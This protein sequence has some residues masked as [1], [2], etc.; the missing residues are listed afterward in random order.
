MS[1]R[2]PAPPPDLPG[3]TV[4]KLLGSGGFADVYLYEQQLPRRSVAV[5]VLLPG[6]AD[7]ELLAQF[8][9]EANLMAALSTH[10]AIV[11]IHQAGISRDGRPYLV[12][13]HCSRP[14]LAARYRSERLGAAEVLRVG[15]RLAGAVE[16][17]HRAGI[18]HRDIK[19]ANVLTTDFGHPVLSDFGISVQSASVRGPAGR[20]SGESGS[21]GMSIPWSAPEVFT[22]HGGDERA[23]IY[24]LAATLYTVLASR[25]PFDRPGGPNT[26]ADLMN[27]IRTAPLPPIGRD[28]IPDALERVITRGMDRN[29]GARF[30]TALDFARAL[31]QVEASLRLSPTPIDVLDEDPQHAAEELGDTPATRVRALTVI[32]PQAPAAGAKQSGVPQFANPGTAAAGGGGGFAPP[33]GGQG[34][35]AAGWSGPGT[36]VAAQQFS[37]PPPA[38]P[39]R[40]SSSL[41][42]WLGGAAVLAVA[43][44]VAVLA[45]N[46][47]DDPA[48]P[49]SGPAL[50]SMSPQG[51]MDVLPAPKVAVKVVDGKSVFSWAPPKGFADGDFY[52]WSTSPDGGYKTIRDTTVTV[53]KPSACLYLQAVSKAGTASETEHRCS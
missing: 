16:T 9:A 51:P 20:P 37:A 1:R 25:S 5:K 28:D 14:N 31:Q 32:H 26:S 44:V 45:L 50:P 3:Y 8:D 15:I 46:G 12:M 10:P 35:A 17:A 7:A 49:P 47:G 42:G 23:D 52:R 36:V 18:L 22:E 34:G 21:V 2:P 40:R 53:P 41:L 33:Q 38:Q 48:P 24:S 13:E 29:R 4:S 11:T 30:A 6:A 39:A 43:A 19:P 27:R